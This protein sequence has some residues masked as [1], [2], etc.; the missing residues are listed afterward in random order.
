LS[1]QADRG[2]TSL[3]THKPRDECQAHARCKAKSRAV[4]TTT[5]HHNMEKRGEEGQ[6]LS[7]QPDDN[8]WKSGWRARGAAR[9]RLSGA[10]LRKKRYGTQEIDLVTRIAGGSKGIDVSEKT[11]VLIH[12]G[13]AAR[14]KKESERTNTRSKYVIAFG[15]PRKSGREKKAR[16]RRAGAIGGC[17]GMGKIHISRATTRKAPTRKHRKK[18]RQVRKNASNLYARV[19]R[20]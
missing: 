11:V 19:R 8:R 14:E 5:E 1:S 16:K 20:R 17:K 12:E 13:E 4:L 18:G 9:S 3:D 15:K 7:S 2:R 6:P 10:G